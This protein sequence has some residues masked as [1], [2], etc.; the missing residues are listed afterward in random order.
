MPARS[1]YQRLPGKAFS[2]LGSSTLWLGAD[3]ILSVRSR[4]LS[5][6]YERFYLREIQAIVLREK[7]GLAFPLE[8]ILILCMLGLGVAALRNYWIAVPA[9][10]IGA[11]YAYQKLCGTRCVGHVKTATGT[12]QLPALSRIRQARRTLALLEPHIAA[13]QGTL[14]AR[15]ALAGGLTPH[16][17]PPPSR[18]DIYVARGWYI[19]QFL[20]VPA[21]AALSVLAVTRPN[22][23][24]LQPATMLASL[25]V[26]ALGIVAIGRSRL[27]EG[28]ERNSA[29]MIIGFKAAKI[30][31]AFLQPIWLGVQVARQPGKLPV[32]TFA[33]TWN[34][35]FYILEGLLVATAIAALV[36]M[37]TGKRRNT[38]DPGLFDGNTGLA[39]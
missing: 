21:S 4:R 27:R 9:V 2:L 12:R 36:T 30:F 26:V 5:E 31:V 17:A 28:V 24:A 15:A 6:D 20:S 13:V 8:L 14:D 33:E 3:H 39:G 32:E 29:W 37:H 34:W 16:L 10:L 23:A 35:V 25:V 7:E 1:Q 19:A 38:S 18:T 11:V 22:N